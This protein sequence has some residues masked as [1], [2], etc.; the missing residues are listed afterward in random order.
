MRP[1]PLSTLPVPL[2][3]YTPLFRSPVLFGPP[4]DLAEAM[5]VLRGAMDAGVNHID[6]SDFY[7]PHIT[8]QI[9]RE[10]LHPYNPALV[11]VTKV[12]GRRGEDAS[13]LPAQT[14]AQLK[15]GRAH[16]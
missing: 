5:A 16:T 13:W 11:I 7:G 9:I 4:R 2:F 12:G 14:Q 10:A 8:N 1:P 3:P 15:T 6:T